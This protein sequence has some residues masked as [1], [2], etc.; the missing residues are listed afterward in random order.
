MN[1]A[2]AGPIPATEL[3]NHRCRIAI[4][5][6]SGNPEHRADHEKPAMPLILPKISDAKTI[7]VSSLVR[8]SP[9]CLFQIKWL[10]R[11]A[12]AG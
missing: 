12:L 4:P 3:T 7:Q 10:W 1:H 11:R 2:T 5:I 9:P 8:D 6:D